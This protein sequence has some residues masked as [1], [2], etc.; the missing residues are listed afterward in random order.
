MILKM[1]YYLSPEKNVLAHNLLLMKITDT[2]PEE[3]KWVEHELPLPGSKMRCFGE[4]R[5]PPL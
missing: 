2:L 4:W 5:L 1:F 3:T